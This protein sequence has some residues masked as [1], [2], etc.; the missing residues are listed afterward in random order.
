LLDLLNAPIDALGWLT[1]SLFL[2]IHALFERFGVPIVF[3]SGLSEATFG[4]GLIFPGVVIMFL[5]GAQAAG[6]PAKVFLVFMVAVLGTV[7]GDT[8]SYGLGR[9]GGRYLLRSARFGPSIRLGTALVEGRARWFIP[10]YHLY[11][12]TRAVGP[13]GAGAVRMPLAA[14][15][16]LDYLGATIANAIWVGS[17]AILGTA[18][19]TDDGRLEQHPALRIGLALGGV[20][21]FLLL[22][23]VVQG[24]LRQLA[25]RPAH[26]RSGSTPVVEVREREPVD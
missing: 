8:V 1:D 17:G 12:M 9:W 20:L 4:V 24:R 23:R 22:R 25:E 6:D 7:I 19:L 10:L 15:L 5:G 16:P 26:P 11:S 21:W 2:F 13:F 3:L 18:V 14:W